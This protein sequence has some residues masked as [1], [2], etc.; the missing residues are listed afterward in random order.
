MQSFDVRVLRQNRRVVQDARRK[1]ELDAFHDVLADISFG[2]ASNA[3]R[4]F[5]VDSFVRGAA[6]RRP[7]NVD[8]EG[9]TAV[10][11]KR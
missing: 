3:V 4:S 10:F 5:I 9:S 6:V 8:F 7:E 1:P 2:R 11:T